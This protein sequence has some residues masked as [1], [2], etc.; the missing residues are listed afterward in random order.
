VLNTTEALAM[1]KDNP[2]SFLY[3]NK[4]E[5]DLPEGTDVYSE[6]VYQKGK[7]N[8]DKFVQNGWLVQDEQEQMYVY[9]IHMDQHV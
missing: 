7:D 3:V 1:A 6:E 5:I 9:T 2:K 4:P 8:L